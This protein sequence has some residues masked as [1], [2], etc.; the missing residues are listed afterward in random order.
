MSLASL[1]SRLI[2]AFVDMI[3]PVERFLPT[4][5]R[6]VAVEEEGGLLLYDVSRGRAKSLGEPSQLGP[7]AIRRSHHRTLELHLPETSLFRRTVRLPRAGRD[8][9]DAILQHRL[10]RLTPWPAHEVMFGYRTVAGGDADGHVLVEIVAASSRVIDR[11]VAPLKAVGLQPTAVGPGTGV[12]DRLPIDLYRGRYDPSR[13]RLRRLATTLGLVIALG[14]VP[15][16]LGSFLLVEREAGRLADVNAQ[17]VD[18][19]RALIAGTAGRDAGGTALALIEG[20][21][22]GAALVTLLD[23]LARLLPD[24]TYL[25]ELAVDGDAVRLVGDSRTAPGLIALLEESAALK[26]VRFAAPVVRTGDGVESFDISAVR[27]RSLPGVE[28]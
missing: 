12:T 7:G 6:L 23:T 15:A 26:D 14:I 18:R 24:G 16:G 22:V 11:A 25:R 19:R 4:A 9:F 2:D 13:R 5:S 17:L 3:A 20:K 27:D 21:Q 28:E 1:P 10:D 8:Y